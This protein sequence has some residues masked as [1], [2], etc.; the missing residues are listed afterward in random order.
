MAGYIMVTEETAEQFARDMSRSQVIAF[1]IE[2]Q[3]L[4]PHTHE[5]LLY[6]FKG[7]NT[8]V[9]VL[10]PHRYPQRENYGDYPLWSGPFWKGKVVLAHN[11]V[12]EYMH[13]N[14]PKTRNMTDLFEAKGWFC[15]ALAERILTNGLIDARADYGFVVKK[16]CGVTL[17]KDLQKSWIGMDPLAIPTEEQLAYAAADVEYLHAIMDAQIARAKRERLLRTFRLEM[18][19]LPAFGE[20]QLNGFYLNRDRHREVVA[21]YVVQ[22]AEARKG[23]VRTL[24]P[25]YEAALAKANIERAKH[26]AYFQNLTQEILAQA[27]IKRLS[28]ETNERVREAVMNCRKQMAKWKP[29]AVDTINL[30]SQSQV[31][32]AMEEAG[33]KPVK[34]EPDGKVKPSLDKNVLRDWQSNELVRVYSAWAK[35]NKVVTTYGDTLAA[36]IHPATGRVHA[37]YNQI[38]NSGRCS[39]SD[40]NAQNMTEAIR[41]CFEAQEGNVLIVAD[42]KNQEGRLA[43]ILSGD[44]NLLQTFRD[45]IDWHSQTAALAYPEKYRSWEDVDKETP[46]KGKEDRAGCKNANFS[47]IYGGTAHTLVARGYVPSLEIGERL[48]QASYSFAPEVRATALRVADRAVEDGVAFTIIGRRRL[49]KLGPRPNYSKEADSEY[50]EWQRTRG[51][52]RRAAMNHPVQGSGADIM[53]Q[54]MIRLLPWMQRNKGKQVGF[55]HDELVY[56]VPLTIADEAAKMVADEM[57]AA[58]ACFTKVLP[59]PGEVHVTKVWKK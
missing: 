43:A 46:G 10:L 51:G 44:K 49:F 55:V 58:A 19:V 4:D 50:A 8:P 37:S 15:T 32:M 7:E 28:K 13:M 25:L 39:S 26:Y 54:A 31:L 9:Y 34:V 30:G 21:E 53:K 47:G 36:K 6:Q 3:G 12:F 23:A 35:P 24:Q 22:E 40:P 17:N 5:I 27:G 38:I 29:K 48:M 14:G 45:G 33:V 18:Q 59:I 42:A 1:D 57:E 2:T 41:A 16:Y 56:E 20:M 11:A 52:I